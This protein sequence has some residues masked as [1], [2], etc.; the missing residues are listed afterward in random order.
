MNLSQKVALNTVLLVG[1]RLAVGASGLVGTIVA[2]R[3][4]G[5]DRFGQL[6]TA[7]TFT[8]LFAVL[9]DAGVWTIASREIARRPDEEQRIVSTASLIG[10][11]LGLFTA[12][13]TVGA[14]FAIYG[15]E[16]RSL[17][18]LGIVI[19][20]V[21]VLLTG[22]LGASSAFLTARQR[23]I[24]GAIA[25]L[26]AA[27]GFL[28][29]LAVVTAWDLGFAGIVTA[30]LVSALLNAAV[31]IL[32]ARRTVSLRPAWDRPLARQLLRWAVPQGFVVAITVIY[33]RVDTVLLSVLAG[34]EDVALYGLSYR[35]LE[36]LLLVP[37]MM[38]LTVFPEIAR[39]TAGSERLRMLVQGLFS[40]VAIVTVPM[41]CVFVGFAPEVIRIAGGPK[42]DDA[43]AV[44]RILVVAVALSFVA[45]VFF[46]ALI[47]LNQQGRL[48]RR[49]LVVLGL[50]VMLNIL[51]IGP[52]AARGAA[53][54]L[55]LSEI[56]ALALAWQLFERTG[57]IVRLRLPARLGAAGL[58]CGAVVAG[59]RLLVAEPAGAPV[60]VL[61]GGSAAAV[62]AFA[63]V[64]LALRALP[65]EVTSALAQL[66]H[67]GTQMPAD[68]A[69]GY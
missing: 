14:A 65:I 10:A 56:A 55:V 29:A 1:G 63:L 11:G 51:L 3:Y 7:V 57:Q 66:R 34:D 62:L 43:A 9:T 67:R 27:I 54:A 68:D 44:L 5:I 26:T 33:I 53:L 64:A 38:S 61:L 17:V 18:R 30:Y 25:G 13:A 4:L 8:A 32:G 35:V 45:G 48:A 22:P 49:M 52:L 42:Y 59:V 28:V 20:A 2:T 69:A 31:L 37:L 21:P 15:G 60:L 19:L 6:Q 12:L 36:F 47:A 40:A 46:H 39:A 50:N 58:A 41:L 16:D 23:A 24:P